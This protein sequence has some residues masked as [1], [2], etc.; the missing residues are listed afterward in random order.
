MCAEITR[1]V[2][3][4][5]G[6]SS[7]KIAVLTVQQGALNLEVLHRFENT[8]VQTS[9]G[10]YWNVLALWKEIIT[11]LGKLRGQQIDSIGA[12]TWA[13]DFALLDEHDLLLDGVHHYRDA[14]TDG[15][16]EKVQDEH[17]SWNIYQRNGIQF[18][19]FNSL[20]QL[21]SVKRDHPHLLSQA[22]TLLM[23]P[24]LLH[25]WL[26]GIKR[27]EI[28]NASTT[29]FFDPVTGQW[30][31]ALLAAL[32][33]PS[34]FLPEVG[35]GGEEAFPLL[36]E[37]AQELHLPPAARVVPPG[38]HDTAS[39]VVAVPATGDNWAFIS[40]GTWSLVGT[41]LQS[42]ILSEEAFEANF[43][44]ELGV[45]GTVRYLKNVM[46]LWILQECRRSWG[47][48]DYPV[49]YR[50]AAEAHDTSTFDVDDRRF[51]AP[52]LDMPERIQQYCREHGLQAPQSRGEVVRSILKSLA[53]QY[54]RVMQDLGRTTGKTFEVLHVVGGGAHI[55]LL[56]QWT[57]DATGLPVHAG[58]ADG[59]LLGNTLTQAMQ[60]R[61]QTLSEIRTML[62]D[63][64]RP[65]VYHP[66]TTLPRAEGRA[67][68]AT[69][70]APQARGKTKRG[71]RA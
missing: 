34:H 70:A 62:I 41:E 24:D 3:I 51:L 38:T 2:G 15:V 61:G 45:S 28:T 22:K 63:S 32:D 5:L 30:D 10:L 20:Y 60:V 54:S 12:D 48:V 56:C 19:P 46:G 50:E 57:A 4:D 6:A 35:K 23:V 37:L 17:G 16:M 52:G 42:P 26:T 36:P 49:L 9:T 65:V 59:T 69:R 7:G 14:R 64:I 11:G 40:S 21:L 18:L 71:P 8:P 33:L 67:V 53:D 58:P 31:H 66:E 1:H 68:S 43:T 47:G 55:E 25:F 13:V 39:A 27:T 29:Q 44:S